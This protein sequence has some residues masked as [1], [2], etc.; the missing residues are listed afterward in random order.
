MSDR[1][2]SAADAAA[3]FGVSTATIR[4][5]AARG[6]LPVAQTLGG[7]KRYHITTT[8]SSTPLPKRLVCVY[9]RVST[10]RQK[11]DLERQI[12]ALL[13]RHPDAEVFSDIASSLQVHR[14]GLTRL[15]SAIVAGKV[16]SVSCTHR[17][18]I[19]RFGLGFFQWICDQH[20]T[21]IIAES[22]DCG[23][24]PEELTE[25]LLAVMHHFSGRMYA[26]RSHSKR[27]TRQ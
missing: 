4:R 23:G 9:A 18:R 8:V 22:S 15:L 13:E 19:A 5:W 7:Q 16:E 25:D 24:C 21:S 26:Q 1:Y 3:H 10:A 27:L 11:A 17:D 12:S 14:P 6:K 2:V 20:R